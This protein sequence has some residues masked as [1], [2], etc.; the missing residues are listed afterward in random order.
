MRTC[1]LRLEVEGQ[2]CG[3][4]VQGFWWARRVGE[5]ALGWMVG[6]LL[7][8]CLAILAGLE[9]GLEARRVE[10]GKARAFVG[11]LGRDERRAWLGLIRFDGL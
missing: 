9:R 2:V 1:L 11:L 4:K 7:L 6:F 5:K 3:Q 10:C 8:G